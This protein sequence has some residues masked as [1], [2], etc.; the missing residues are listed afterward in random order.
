MQSPVSPCETSE[1]SVPGT[2]LLL[3]SLVLKELVAGSGHHGDEGHKLLEV[4]FC[5]SVSVQGFHDF[6]HHLLRFDFL[7]EKK[8]WPTLSVSGL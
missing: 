6:V 8:K 7:R 4:A 3:L 1:S 5:V 2:A